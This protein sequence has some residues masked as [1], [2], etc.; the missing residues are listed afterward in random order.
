MNL[1]NFGQIVYAPAMYPPGVVFSTTRVS[2]P[3]QPYQLKMS[4]T[5]IEQAVYSSM[6]SKVAAESEVTG[7]EPQKLVVMDSGLEVPA[8]ILDR[9]KQRKELAVQEQ[10]QQAVR[11]RR[12]RGPVF[13]EVGLF[14]T[15]SPLQ[16]TI[17]A[18]GAGVIAAR[19]YS[20]YKTK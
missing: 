19:I 3:T 9:E 15:K 13:V 1:R 10:Q 5:Q 17:M 12:R 8:Y 20:K 11:A 6:P 7:T 14:A 4:D 18:L 2:V 16:A